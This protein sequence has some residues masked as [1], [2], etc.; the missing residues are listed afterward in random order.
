MEKNQIK[1]RK[2]KNKKEERGNGTV[3]E[4]KKKIII[5]VRKRKME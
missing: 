1:M 3:Q 2:I 5:K 4:K